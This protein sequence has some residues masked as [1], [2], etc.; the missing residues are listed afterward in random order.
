MTHAASNKVTE[1]AAET[2]RYLRAAV[3]VEVTYDSDTLPILD[4]YLR[5]L[6]RDNTALVTLVIASAGAYFGEVVRRTIGG[7]WALH[8]DGDGD[9][10]GW[11][12][13]LPTGLSFSPA[14]V[15]T[16]VI[17]RSDDLD[18][19]DSGLHVPGPLQSVSE[20]VLG[21]MSEVSEDEYYS[22][23]GRYD[24]LAHLEDVLLAVVADRKAR[25]GHSGDSDVN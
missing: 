9:P 18:A 13:F 12:L 22:L 19:L 16:S 2:V 7:R 11:R 20:E 5:T 17:A 14:G 21:R 15:V 10:A 4:H 6:P 8:D 25:G 1:L 24:A 23:C 3:G